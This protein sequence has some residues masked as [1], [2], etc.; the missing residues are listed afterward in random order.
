MRTIE[1]QRFVADV[2]NGTAQLHLK[3]VEKGKQLPWQV[4]VTH[5]GPTSGKSAGTLAAMATEEEGRDQYEFHLDA[6]EKKGWTKALSGRVKL[7]PGVPEPDSIG[8]PAA[9]PA[10]RKPRRPRKQR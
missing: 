5:E 10:R 9:E 4:L 1:S 3:L 6:A 8:A 7:W 2:A